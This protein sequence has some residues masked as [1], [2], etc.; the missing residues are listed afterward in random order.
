MIPDRIAEAIEQCHC[1]E[2]AATNL[3]GQFPEGITASQFLTVH[4]R[5]P[6]PVARGI[7]MKE[8]PCLR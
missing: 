1:R 3:V 5:E 2:T 4:L 6:V 7:G 8:L